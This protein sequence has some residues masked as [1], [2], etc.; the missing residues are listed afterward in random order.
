MSSTLAVDFNELLER[1]ERPP[2]V[3]FVDD[4]TL[5]LNALRRVMRPYRFDLMTATGGAAALALFAE[6]EIDLVVSDHDMP[7]MSGI[8]LLRTIAER[9]PNTVRY[10][11][12]GKATLSLAL[13]AINEGEIHRFFTKPCCP[14][15]LALGLRHGLEQQRLLTVAKHLF[16]R[17][18]EQEQT[19]RQLETEHP[20]IGEINRDADGAIILDPPEA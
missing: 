17:C 3:L 4:E 16:A 12:T 6:H 14:E 5:V 10:M 13:A 1:T 8:E 19:L 20:G 9:W 11:L 15:E 7:G 2:R 18:R